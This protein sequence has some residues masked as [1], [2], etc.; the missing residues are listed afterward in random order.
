MSVMVKFPDIKQYRNVVKEVKDRA[1]YHKVPLPKLSFNGSVKLHGTNA[2]VVYDPYTT[3]LWCQSRENVI[4]P[5]KDNAGFARFVAENKQNFMTIVN[6]AAT[7][8]GQ[9]LL[10]PGDLIAVYGE[11]C[12]GS[13]QKK[14]ALNELSKMF[15]IFGIKIVRIDEE[16]DD[17]R[18]SIWFTVDEL[19]KVAD[20]LEAELPEG[21]QIFSIQKFK[22]WSVEIDF[23]YPEVVI[24]KLVELTADV[25]ACC[26]VGDAFGVKGTGEGIVWRCSDLWSGTESMIKTSDLVF[27]VKGEK[28]SD[29]KVK[30]QASVDIEKINSIRE[31]AL[32]FLTDHRLEKMIELMKVDGDQI[33]ME[34]T[35]IFLKRVGNDV[36]KEELDVIEGN[37]FTRAEVMPV[38]NANARQ[39]YHQY[40]NSNF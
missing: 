1:Q 18:F 3:E 34:T 35:G 29:T 30:K 2:S 12:G 4:T 32:S 15:V 16:R 17:E 27:K 14:V 7:T 23:A 26:P 38:L 5:E 11:W 28:H 24:N 10:R 40:I 39:W 9:Q 8:F 6:V 22:T 37:G 20:Q 31:L 21:C 19:I 13:I 25:E 33:A 36:L